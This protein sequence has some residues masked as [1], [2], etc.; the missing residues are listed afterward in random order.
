MLRQGAGTGA[1]AWAAEGG[2]GERG[3]DEDSRQCQQAQELEQARQRLEARA[4]A[5]A[6]AEEQQYLNKVKAREGRHGSRKGPKPKPP[7]AVPAPE[8]QINLVDEDSRLMRKN[9]RSEYEQSY[10]AQAVVDAEGS[11]LVLAARVSQCASDCNELRPDVEEIPAS[12]G[13]PTAVLADSGYDCEE[14]VN[15]VQS[16]QTEVYVSMGNQA[17]QQGRTHDFRP[18]PQC[19]QAPRAT[20][21]PWRRAMKEKLQTDTGRA[22]YARR[23]QTVEPVFGIIKH[24]MGF[25][26]F[27]LRGAEKVSGEW[28][29]VTLAYNMK[30][31][32]NLK[33]AHA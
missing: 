32:W 12:L 22:L 31:L 4:Q 19:A 9:K 3:R 2:H 26:Q 8:E 15:A 10:N 11:Q 14:Q 1:G 30:R 21:A 29:L 24:A 6:K 33:L 25:R 5:R 18:R 23:K 7:S 28:E 13:V 27:L 20:K 16:E 17:G